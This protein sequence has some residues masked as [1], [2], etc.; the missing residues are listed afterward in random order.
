M[1][2]LPQRTYLPAST[3]DFHPFHRTTLHSTKPPTCTK[4]HLTKADINEPTTTAKRKNRQLNNTIWYNPPFSKNVSNNIGLKFLNLT[5]KHFPKDHRLRKIFNRNTIKISYS[6]MNNAK[7]IIDKRILH[8]S[9]KKDN[10]GGTTNKTCNCRQ[11]NREFQHQRRERQQ[12]LHK[13]R[14]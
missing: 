13:L 10:K 7:Q 1:H 6:C 4:K 5:D 2:R 8:S 14:I 3:N 12:Q 11:K 9:Y